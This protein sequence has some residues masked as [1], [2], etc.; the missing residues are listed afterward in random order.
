MSFYNYIKLI[1]ED[2]KY[3]RYVRITVTCDL[4]PLFKDDTQFK[5][6][7]KKMTSGK[8]TSDFVD[9]AKPIIKS[10]IEDHFEKA[11]KATNWMAD[12]SNDTTDKDI[13]NGKYLFS[14]YASLK[15]EK[16]ETKLLDYVR[17]NSSKFEVADTHEF[18][19]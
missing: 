18:C 6:V 3:P 2:N 9:K 19:L 11:N 10:A 4:D 12:T 17:S 14:I 1:T 13:R 5:A 8:E 7:M 15:N 16:I